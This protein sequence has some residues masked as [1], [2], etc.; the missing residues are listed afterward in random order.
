MA[1]PERDD[2]QQAREYALALPGVLRRSGWYDR[3][4]LQEAVYQWSATRLPLDVIE[5]YLAAGIADPWVAAECFRE[6]GISARQIRGAGIGEQISIGSMSLEDAAKVLLGPRAAGGLDQL[7]AALRHEV[8]EL[9]SEDLEG[10]ARIDHLRSKSIEG[11]RWWEARVE[12]LAGFLDDQPPIPTELPAWVREQSDELLLG[13]RAA[14]VSWAGPLTIAVARLELERVEGALGRPG[15]VDVSG[16]LMT[17]VMG[18]LATRELTRRVGERVEAAILAPPAYV[19]AMLGPYPRVELAQLAWTQA[20]LAIEAFRLECGIDDAEHALGAPGFRVPLAARVQFQALNRA[21]TRVGVELEQGRQSITAQ[22]LPT[23]GPLPDLDHLSNPDP[24]VDADWGAGQ[25]VDLDSMRPDEELSW[26]L[27]ARIDVFPAAYQEAAAALTDADLAVRWGRAVERHLHD[28]LWDSLHTHGG[29][30]ALWAG[31][32][33]DEAARRLH[34]R[35]EAIAADPPAYL[36]GTLGPRPAEEERQGEWLYRAEQIE[37]YRLLTGTTDPRHAL[38]SIPAPDSSWQQ[39]WRRELAQDLADAHKSQMTYQHRIVGR[40]SERNDLA[41]LATSTVDPWFG[42]RPAA[43]LAD[44]CHELSVGELRRRVAAARPL[45]TDRPENHASQ[46]RE[47]QQRRAELLG[48]K[49]EEEVA[50]AAATAKREE[51]RWATGRGAKTARVTAQAAVDQ[52]REALTNLDDR[53]ADAERELTRREGAQTAYFD[54]C[55]QH[56]LE[57]SQGQAAA[58]VLQERETRLLE[59]LAVY[60]PPYLLAEL[61]QPPTNRDGRAAWLRGAHAIERHR[62]AYDIFDREQAFGDGDHIERLKQPGRRQDRERA[63][64]LVDDARRAITESAARQ[65]H[66]GLAMPGIEDDPGFAIGA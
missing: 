9:S 5:E 19:T 49:A 55:R 22:E 12:H 1:P 62:A 52:H 45:L 6:L 29:A 35:V 64:D 4:S 18:S 27:F 7:R 26:R 63:G 56:A 33:R 47:V 24:E 16:Y 34:A 38:G 10:R 17:L 8:G 39:C 58:Q 3:A 61:G 42:V 20:V 41:M 60:P 2:P 46:V 14:G 30:P 36:T 57:V 66:E 23:A 48:Y 32:I 28:E 43:A 13:F 54:W 59:D 31:A 65:L 40:P 25:L 37:E 15:G 44:E 51:L 21:L 11:Y 53:L 50:L